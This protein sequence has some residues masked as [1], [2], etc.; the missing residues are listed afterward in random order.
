MLE[1][2]KHFLSLWPKSTVHNI[3]CHRVAKVFSTS[4]DA[5]FSFIKRHIYSVI[6][7]VQLVLHRCWDAKDRSGGKKLSVMSLIQKL[8]LSSTHTHVSDYTPGCCKAK[9]SVFIFKK[10]CV[11][12]C[13]CVCVWERGG[14]TFCKSWDPEYFEAIDFISPPNAEAQ[15]FT[16]LGEEEPM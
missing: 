14:N 5:P 6:L 1:L 15:S 8:S 11:C 10:R 9:P 12:Q 4:S 2:K 7:F 3:S 16:L 13:K